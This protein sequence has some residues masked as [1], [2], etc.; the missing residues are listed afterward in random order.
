MHAGSSLCESRNYYLIARYLARPM[1]LSLASTVLLAMAHS[2]H[3][4]GI[5]ASFLQVRKRQSKMGPSPLQFAMPPE[6]RPQECRNKQYDLSAMPSVSVVIP[7]LHEDLGLIEKTV[8]SLLANTP[9]QLLDEILL[10]D[11]ENDESHSYASVLANLDPK[12]KV[13]R[14]KERQGLIKAKVTGAA[15]TKSPVIVFLEPHCTANRQWLEPLLERML[16][17]HRRVVVPIIDILPEDHTDDYSY[18][19]TAYG[20]FGWNLEFTWPGDAHSRN[21]SYHLPDPYPMPSMSGG[22]FAIWRDWWEESGTYDS[23]MREWGS[24]HIEMSLRTWRCGGSVEAVPC[25]R[26]G[27][28]F[29]KARPYVFHGEAA[30]HNKK[31]LVAVW[32]DNHTAEVKAAAGKNVVDFSDAGDLEER[33][34][35]KQRLGCKSM[36]WYI[37]NVYP[38]LGKQKQ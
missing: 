26:V 8:G 6:G 10:V 14:N 29:R 22:L 23:E 28:M 21:S 9:S 17:S 32:L 12:V 20:G 38:E 7:Y 4:Q 18:A 19:G 16:A 11:D 35:L 33:K 24:E 1:I 37:K 30:I 27:H 2:L 3:G 25:S 13:H 36:D 34:R 31:R 5:G 15:A